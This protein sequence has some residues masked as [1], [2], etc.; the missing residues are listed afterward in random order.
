[1]EDNL[2]RVTTYRANLPLWISSS[3]SHLMIKIRTLKKNI[4]NAFDVSKALNIK[5]F[6]IHAIEEADEDLEI[7]EAQVF[8]GRQISTIQKHLPCIRKKTS[9]PTKTFHKDKHASTEDEST[10]LFNDFS[11]SV[12]TDKNE[13]EVEYSNQTLNWFKGDQNRVETLL[14]KLKIGKATD[15]DNLGNV[16]LKNT[17][18]SISKSLTL[19]FQTTIKKGCFPSQWKTSQIWPIFKDE[20]RKHVS[21]Y[22]PLSLLCCVSTVIEKLIF[23][24]IYTHTRA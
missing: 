24:V 14:I 10:Q 19:V 3:T 7:H 15:P 12:F 4:G 11:I 21:C 1:M 5:K 9:I 17:A 2:D 18:R 22:R 8:S 13:L 20:E 16:F 6:E 23:E